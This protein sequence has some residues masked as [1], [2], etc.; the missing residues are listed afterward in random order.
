VWKCP[1]LLDEGM[2]G[3]NLGLLRGISA[4]VSAGW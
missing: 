3:D 4:D 1:L 2:A